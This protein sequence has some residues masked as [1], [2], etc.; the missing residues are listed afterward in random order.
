MCNEPSLSSEISK[1]VEMERAVAKGGARRYSTCNW[2]MSM[3]DYGWVRSCG[4][5]SLGSTRSGRSSEGDLGWKLGQPCLPG[6][7][8]IRKHFSQFLNSYFFFSTTDCSMS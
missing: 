1:T 5:L 2:G 7:H 8:L 4:S 3:L 6:L